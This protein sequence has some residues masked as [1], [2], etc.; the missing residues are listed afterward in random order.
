MALSAS[1]ESQTAQLGNKKAALVKE[2]RHG[3]GATGTRKFLFSRL[4]EY[5]IISVQVVRRR[6]ALPNKG[7]MLNDYI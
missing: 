5:P 2:G 7:V 3:I 1:R 4:P 6:L